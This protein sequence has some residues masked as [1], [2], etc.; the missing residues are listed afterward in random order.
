MSGDVSKVQG[1]VGPVEPKKDSSPADAEKFQAVLREQTSKVSG[2]DPD[3]ERRR[4]RQQEAEEDA[5][6]SA[7]LA[8]TQTPEEPK[9]P[10]PFQVTQQPD[11]VGRIGMRARS[12]QSAAN[13]A[14]SPTEL[15][16]ETWGEEAPSTVPSTPTSS[17]PS[18]PSPSTRSPGETPSTPTQE[19]SSAT[20]QQKDSTHPAKEAETKK[21]HPPSKT[22]A[23]LLL[24][25]AKITEEKTHKAHAAVEEVSLQGGLVTSPPPIIPGTK[26]EAPSLPKKAS[27]EGLA[28]TIPLVPEIPKETLGFEPLGNLQPNNPYAKL[29]PEVQALFERI[30]GVISVMQQSGIKETS[31]TLN[32]P[33]FASSV[34]FG[35]RIIIREFSTAAKAFNIEFSGS[36]AAVSL[37]QANAS[38]LAAAFQAGNYAFRVHRMETSYLTE[39]PLFKRKEGGQDSQQQQSGDS[40]G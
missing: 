6:A 39:R 34:F 16:T 30:V 38:D 29:H 3:E 31:F 17:T 12:E 13:V 4:K 33:Q 10:A 25:Q 36:E 18:T 22:D 28:Q 26:P 15:Y 37:F 32:M 23:E 21:G 40:H 8:R 5:R 1:P 11:H 27:I 24:K 9:D 20:P 14:P 7:E 35:S 2:V 19:T